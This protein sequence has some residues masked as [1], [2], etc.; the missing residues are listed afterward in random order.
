MKRLLCFLIPSRC[1]HS[2]RR[3]SLSL[4]MGLIVLWPVAAP[5]VA[6]GSTTIQARLTTQVRR[7]WDHDVPSFLR[8]AGIIPQP[9]EHVAQQ[10]LFALD[11]H[12]IAGVMRF[13]DHSAP[14]AHQDVSKALHRWPADMLR[15]PGCW[16]RIGPYTQDVWFAALPEGSVRRIPLTL[17]SP[18]ETH[19]LILL[20]RFN[21]R[22]WQIASAHHQ[23]IHQ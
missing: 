19:E 13:V 21:G 11:R 4:L 6:V 2:F 10:V 5:D 9:P 12:D 23:Q 15:Q 7:L 1:S 14:S 16:G 8:R 17:S 20:M 3:V 22:A 18:R